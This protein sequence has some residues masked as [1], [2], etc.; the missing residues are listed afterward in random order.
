MEHTQEVCI[1]D[2]DPEVLRSTSLLLQMMGYKAVPFASGSE[3]LADFH[4]QRP[5]CVL[6]DQRM[7]GLTGIDVL[8]AL[9]DLGSDVPVILISGHA[10][11]ELRGKLIDPLVQLLEKPIDHHL[12]EKAL[13]TATCRGAKVTD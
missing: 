1:V 8:G 10:T 2:D 5:A 9:R 7:P 11:A 4:N 3:F 6:I 12:L 13:W